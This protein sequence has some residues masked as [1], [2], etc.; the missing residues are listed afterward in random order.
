MKIWRRMMNAYSDLYISE[1]QDWLGEYLETSVYVLNVELKEAWRYFIMSS[2]SMSFAV[3]NPFTICGKSGSEVAFELCGK[4][5]KQL[6]FIYDRTPEYWLGWAIA[7]YQWE[8][9][10]PFM[11]ITNKVNIETILLMYKKYHETDITHF[12]FEM[13]RLMTIN[14]KEA[15]LKRMRML[16]GMSQKELADITSIPIRTIQQYEQ[17]QKNINNAQA[18][19]ILVLAQALSCSPKDILEY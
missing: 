9:N 12:C 1:A 8:K 11:F 15:N 7:Y 16:R 18:N 10:I 4:R 5:V 6:P 19:Y 13:D 14:K 17:R 2:Y 3:G